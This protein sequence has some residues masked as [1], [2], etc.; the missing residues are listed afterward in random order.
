MIASNLVLTARHCVEKNAD[1]KRWIVNTHRRN[2]TNPK[3]GG[4][5]YGVLKILQHADFDAAVLVLGKPTVR[6][7]FSPG[8][9][10]YNRRATVPS[11]NGRARVIGWGEYGNGQSADVGFHSWEVAKRGLSNGR[12]PFV[13]F[14][15]S[16]SSLSPN[17]ALYKRSSEKPISP[18]NHS[19]L[20]MQ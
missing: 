9:V 16:S 18:F 20:D 4:I 11:P 5:A 3:E 17:F 14:S 2:V 8:I 10:A 1:P 13:S 15:S 12:L 19:A 7:S 6:G